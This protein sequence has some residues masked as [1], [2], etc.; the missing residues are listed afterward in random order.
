[1]L[2]L[3]LIQKVKLMKRTRLTSAVILLLSIASL[4]AQQ[5]ANSSGGDGS[6]SGGTSSYT[7]G[8]TVYTTAS[9]TGGST[10]QGVQQTYEVSV[11]SGVDLTDI[12]FEMNAYPNPTTSN[13]TLT[14]A[15]ASDLSYKLYD[16]KGNEV[17]SNGITDQAT[18]ISLEEQ[19]TA[20]YFLKVLQN[21]TPL[22][23]FKIVKY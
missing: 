1:M 19:P 8:Q 4:Q 23:T 7:V 13:L 11:V 10:S 3:S 18:Q 15:D 14:V 16:L 2:Y 20:V 21:N 17:E 6:G 12:L 22:K 5:S 9:G